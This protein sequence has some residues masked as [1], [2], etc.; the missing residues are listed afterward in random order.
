MN[1][2]PDPDGTFRDVSDYFL[3]DGIDALIV[4]IRERPWKSGLDAL[5]KGEDLSELMEAI[6]HNAFAECVK[7]EL[8]LSLGKA[9]KCI[10]AY[11]EFREDFHTAK[12]LLPD[13]LLRLAE[14]LSKPARDEVR[15]FWKLGHQPTSTNIDIWIITCRQNAAHDKREAQEGLE[16]RR[17]KAWKP[18]TE[19]AR[20]ERQRKLEWLLDNSFSILNNL[21]REDRIA[22][23][24]FLWSSTAPTCKLLAT[25]LAGYQRY[26]PSVR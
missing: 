1:D 3:H 15:R 16:K 4:R 14:P 24:D 23:A 12:S 2:Q 5:R 20:R 10:A 13:T 18:R 6:G 8:D 19:R 22:V 17:A 7:A 25:R 9:K 21:A 11:W 26:H